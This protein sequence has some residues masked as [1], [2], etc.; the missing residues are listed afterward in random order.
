MTED[1]TMG[2][3]HTM[4]PCPRCKGSKG[5][6]GFVTRTTGCDG[7]EWIDCLLCRGAGAI[8]RVRE[9]QFQRGQRIYDARIAKDWSLR[10]F[11]AQLGLRPHEASDIENGRSLN[12]WMHRA[13]V[14]LGL[15]NDEPPTALGG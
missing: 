13:E 10:E 2:V 6:V 14:L 9:Q 11:A 8:T 5:G 1:T 15:R 12:E 4:V 7:P 3:A